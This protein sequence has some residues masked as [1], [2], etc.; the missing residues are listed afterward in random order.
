[1]KQLDSA[2]FAANH[3]NVVYRVVWYIQ[4]S[5]TGSALA[6]LFKVTTCPTESWL[7]TVTLDPHVKECGQ[8]KS[9][10]RYERSSSGN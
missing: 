9:L 7:R 3:W 2:N 8:T 5:P 1:M 10:L 4:D 6:L